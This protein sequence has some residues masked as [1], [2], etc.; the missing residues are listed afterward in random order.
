MTE[1]HTEE[2]SMSCTNAVRK[3]DTQ[4]C[5]RGLCTDSWF[6]LTGAFPRPVRQQQ[7]ERAQTTCTDREHLQIRRQ[8]CLTS[9][10]YRQSRASEQNTGS[11]VEELVV[12]SGKHDSDKHG[13]CVDQCA[14]KHTMKGMSCRNQ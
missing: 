1:N 5:T 6:V 4:E 12:D 2:T 11:V 10:A 13:S 14:W 9:F 7:A 3:T 8:F